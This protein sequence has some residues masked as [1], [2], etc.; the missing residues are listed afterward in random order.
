MA[1]KNHEKFATFHKWPP[2]FKQQWLSNGHIFLLRDRIEESYAGGRIEGTDAGAEIHA[3]T[4][5]GA[6]LLIWEVA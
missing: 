2:K 4:L 5:A 1:P 3:Q 6:Y